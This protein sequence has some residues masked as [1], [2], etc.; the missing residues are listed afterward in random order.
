MTD[1]TKIAELTR[2]IKFAMV[3]FVNHEGHLHAAPMTTQDEDF[4]GTVWF[5][6]SKDSD[7]V[8]SIPGNAQV[9]LGY[10]DTAGHNYVS[11]NGTAEL[12][13]DK[14]KLDELWSDG[15][16]AFFEQGKE[17]PKIQLI[18]V[19]GNGAQYWEGSGRVVSMIKMAKAAITGDTAKL[20]ETEGVK[21]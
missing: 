18:K 3:T 16:N 1:I 6:G 7:L 4:N 14:A 2:G 8:R 13:N 17:D 11:I 15:Y 12:V 10:S 20:G 5:I 9:N 19:V 21:L